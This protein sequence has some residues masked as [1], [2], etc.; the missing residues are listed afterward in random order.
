VGDFH[1]LI[2]TCV[3]NLTDAKYFL[4]NSAIALLCGS[5][6]RHE[7]RMIQYKIGCA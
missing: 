3:E 2:N 7:I 1:K 4:W 5:F 6:D